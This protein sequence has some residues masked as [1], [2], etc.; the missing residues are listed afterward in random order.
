MKQRIYN[1][2]SLDFFDSSNNHKAEIYI[3]GSDL[4]LNPVDAAGT[5]IIGEGGSVNDIEVGEVGT[6]VNF[7][8]LGGGTIS[9]NGGTLTLGASGD[10]VDLSNTTIAV[11]T[12]SIFQGGDIFADDLELI[13]AFTASDGNITG[14]LTVGGT[15]TAQEF[16]TEFTSASIIYESGSTKFG[17]TSDDI[18]SFSGSFRIS[19]SGDH[20]F[21][22]G[23][24]GIGTTSP[25]QKLDVRGSLIVAGDT[26]VSPIGADLEV[27]KNGSTAKLLIHQD[28]ATASSTFAQVS[29]RNGGND[30][31]IKVPPSGNGLLIDVESASE[32]FAI[33]TTG[34]VGIGTT[35]P[36]TI[37]D[38]RSRRKYILQ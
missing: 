31:H 9:S 22:D 15:I 17:D 11:I 18:H 19:G 26:P 13:N 36:E 30:T 29:F 23:N 21:T 7:T 25:S 8:F 33:S 16:H 27:Y 4:V 10:T 35:S 20:Y 28:D 3:S 38:I 14:D 12:A 6:P 5:V 37:L 2:N 1:G 24:V 32:V 34:N